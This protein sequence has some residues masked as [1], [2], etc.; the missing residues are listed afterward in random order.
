MQEYNDIYEFLPDKLK[1]DEEIIKKAI[2]I[3]AELDYTDARIKPYLNEKIIKQAINSGYNV[4][5]KDTQLKTYFDEESLVKKALEKSDYKTVI[6]IM[7]DRL[8][9]EETLLKL[10]KQKPTFYVSL[11]KKDARFRKPVFLKAALKE[12]PEIYNWFPDDVK[13]PET[14]E[15]IMEMGILPDEYKDNDMMVYKMLSQG[16]L[17]ISDVSPRLQQN[18]NVIEMALKINKYIGSYLCAEARNNPQIMILIIKREASNARY[19]SHQLASNKAFILKLK[20]LN[21]ACKKYL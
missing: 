13:T 10:I 18:K 12:R 15:Y 1:Y 3:G 11:I 20:L 21:P 9:D 17:I 6:K 8:Q 2:Q 5:Y 16:H 7:G 19:L 14:R 4:D